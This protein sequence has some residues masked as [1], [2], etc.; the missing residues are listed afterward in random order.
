MQE[1]E[2]WPWC[3]K[4]VFVPS[5]SQRKEITQS[6]MARLITYGHPDHHHNTQFTNITKIHSSGSLKEAHCTYNE[7]TMAWVEMSGWVLARYIRYGSA[8]LFTCHRKSMFLI[9]FSDTIMAGNL[10][11]WHFF[12]HHY[13]R[14]SIFWPFFR[15]YSGQKCMLLII[16]S[17][18][19]I[20]AFF[21]ETILARKSFIF[22]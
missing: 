13:G 4:F 6:V 2:E 7:L 22:G 15:D 21:L 3:S 5:V 16:F 19:Y 8:N 20:L 1:K 17:V 14:K 9:I 12:G 18:I 10:Y 11:F